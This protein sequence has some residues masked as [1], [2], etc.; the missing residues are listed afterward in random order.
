MRYTG[1]AHTLLFENVLSLFEQ[2]SAG[3]PVLLQGVE[4]GV[5]DVPLHIIYMKS[6]LITGQVIVRI[7]PTLPV[8][9]LFMLLVIYT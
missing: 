8:Q 1:A 7:R 3:G 5:I 9:G 4:L 6:D 2:S